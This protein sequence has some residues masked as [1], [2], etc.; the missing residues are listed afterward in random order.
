[1]YTAS[2]YSSMPPLRPMPEASTT[3]KG[4]AGLDTLRRC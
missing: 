3:P 1:M 4:A 2:T